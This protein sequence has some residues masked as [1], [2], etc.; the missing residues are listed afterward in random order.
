MKLKEIARNLFISLQERDGIYYVLK[1]GE[2][3]HEIVADSAE[4]AIAKFNEEYAE[5]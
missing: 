2:F 5:K 1:D 3:D 4:E